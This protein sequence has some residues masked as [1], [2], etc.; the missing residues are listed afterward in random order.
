[1]AI[2][3]GIEILQYE[4]E[5]IA[6]EIHFAYSVSDF[7]LLINGIQ[8]MKKSVCLVP[9]YVTTEA[10]TIVRAPEDVYRYFAIQVTRFGATVSCTP[11]EGDFSIYG[12]WVDPNPTIYSHDFYVESADKQVIRF[13]IPANV[14]YFRSDNYTKAYFS[15]QGKKFNNVGK[16]ELINGVVCSNLT[17]GGT[18][19][20]ESQGS[21]VY[22]GTTS[23]G[24]LLSVA[25]LLVFLGSN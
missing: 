3:I 9:E 18:C 8:S 21:V 13:E 17:P 12:S 15:L 16:V 5:L 24:R 1:M 10:Q 19:S 11:S 7:G 2:G 25:I 20:G 22:T 14:S 23:E 6:S 4:L